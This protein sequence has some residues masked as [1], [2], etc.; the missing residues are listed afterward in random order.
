MKYKLTGLQAYRLTGVQACGARLSPGGG[1]APVE[2]PQREPVGNQ[3]HPVK[4]DHQPET[5]LA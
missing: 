1:D 3:P 5:S 4:A 2:T